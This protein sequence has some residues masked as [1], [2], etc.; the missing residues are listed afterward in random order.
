MARHWFWPPIDR[1]VSEATISTSQPARRFINNQDERKVMNNKFDELAKNTAR[2]VTR[3]Q[4]LRRFGL[5]IAGI[6]LALLGLAFEAQAKQP[7][8]KFKCQC[9]NPPYW[10]CMTQDCFAACQ[11]F[12]V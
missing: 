9:N 3:R 11:L 6:G 10:G 4:A 1:A 8:K 7:H 5:G 12:C 2:A